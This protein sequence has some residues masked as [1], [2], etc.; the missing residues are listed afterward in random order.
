[1]AKI[2]HIIDPR[3]EL[4]ATLAQVIGGIED[5][6]HVDLW[7]QNVEFIEKDIPWPRPAVFVEFES[8]TWKTIKG[9]EFY[10]RYLRGDGTLRLHI[11]T[12]WVDGG[13]EKALSLSANIWEELFNGEWD[14]SEN[15]SFEIAFPSQSVTNHNHDEILETV[16]VFA[17]RYLVGLGPLG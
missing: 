1:M 16:D 7:N 4:Y 5:I 8:I 12:D 10:R 3:S 15:P 9:D 14:L 11:V 2:Q 6:K 13:Q 17:V